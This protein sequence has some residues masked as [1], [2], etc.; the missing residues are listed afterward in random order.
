MIRN[1]GVNFALKAGVPV[2]TISRDSNT[3]EEGEGMKIRFLLAG[4]VLVASLA[5]ASPAQANTQYVSAKSGAASVPN[6]SVQACSGDVCQST[7]P[8]LGVEL[9]VNAWTEPNV[10][11]PTIVSV[12]CPSGGAAMVVR[13]G[14]SSSI[15]WATLVGIRADGSLHGQAVGFPVILAANATSMVRAC[16]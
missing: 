12:A 8:L 2:P 11:P 5:T 4:G 13:G 9:T 16:A 14:S 10:T 1:G 3:L 7:P 6:V 15:V